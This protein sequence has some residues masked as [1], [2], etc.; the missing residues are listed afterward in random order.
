ME[1]KFT[2][3]VWL[4]KLRGMIFYETLNKDKI[5]VEIVI[6]KPKSLRRLAMAYSLLTLYNPLEFTRIYL[7]IYCCLLF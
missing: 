2:R 3:R 7:H 5:S 1:G 4:G 6:L